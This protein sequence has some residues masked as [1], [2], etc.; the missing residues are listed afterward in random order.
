[1]EKER[2]LTEEEKLEK[3]FWDEV[4]ADLKYILPYLRLIASF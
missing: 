1:M 3:K 2:V 4:Y